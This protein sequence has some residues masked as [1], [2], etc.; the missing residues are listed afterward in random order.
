MVVGLEGGGSRNESEEVMARVGFGGRR[1][2]VRG[3]GGLN[4]Y[5]DDYECSWRSQNGGQTFSFRCSITLFGSPME[6]QT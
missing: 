5:R 6:I 1:L 2:M 3:G 4:I